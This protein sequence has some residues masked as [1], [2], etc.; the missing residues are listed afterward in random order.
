MIVI[1]NCLSLVYIVSNQSVNFTF[2]ST[3]LTLQ[4]YKHKMSEILQND[5]G[6]VAW[7]VDPMCTEYTCI[8]QHL[9]GIWHC[10]STCTKMC[11]VTINNCIH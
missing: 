1:H 9:I 2:L 10:N 7:Q 6:H 3:K 11:H 8:D 4:S 5:H